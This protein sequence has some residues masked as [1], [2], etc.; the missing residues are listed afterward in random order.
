[1]TPFRF[2]VASLVLLPLAVSC[3]REPADPPA[4]PVITLHP[5]NGAQAAFITVTGLST[6]ERSSLR[7]ARLSPAG[8]PPIV[9][10]TVGE[11]AGD[12]LPPVQGRYEVT[13]GGI[14]FT[15]LFPFDPGRAYRVAVDLTRLPRPR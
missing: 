2:L 14:Q 3:R 10:V 11:A 5:Q 4:T 7:E 9:R 1:M 12:G 8:W 13:D 15:P 6:S